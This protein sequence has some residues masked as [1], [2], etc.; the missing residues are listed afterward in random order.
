[1][2][3]PSIITDEDVAFFYD[4]GYLVKRQVISPDVVDELRRHAADLQQRYLKP[5]R[6]EGVFYTTPKT[7]SFD[8]MMD[9]S[10]VTSGVRNIRGILWWSRMQGERL[11]S[12]VPPANGS[13]RTSKTSGKYRLED[14]W[15]KPAPAFIP[16]AQSGTTKTRLSLKDGGKG[17]PGSG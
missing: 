10:A 9:G 17:P 6:E 11:F 15:I 8:A 7:E 1:M 16:L 14:S 12:T 3:S 2:K 4:N 13:L 5:I